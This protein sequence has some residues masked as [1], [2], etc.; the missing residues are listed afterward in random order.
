MTIGWCP[1]NLDQLRS[2]RT[3]AERGG[4]SRAAEALYL[5]QSTISMQIAAL[6]RELGVSLFD[7][8]GRRVTL[9]DAGQQLLRYAVSI[10][11]LAEE[12]RRAMEEI[13][14]IT[15][16]KLVIGA[17]RIIGTY[18]V[19]DLFGRFNADHPGVKLI[20][21]TDATARTAERVREGSLDVGLL[22]ARVSV[23]ELVIRPFR[24]D[25]LVLIVPP[26]H[27][28][29]ERGEIDA[30]ELVTERLITREP[31]EIIRQIVDR[32]LR[33]Q[34]IELKPTLELWAFEAIR[35]AVTA[36]LGVAIVPR[37]V[38]NL[39]LTAGV[40]AQVAVR[41]VRLQR[42]LYVALHRQKHIS[43]ALAAFLGLLGLNAGLVLGSAQ[44]GT[45][46]SL[47]AKRRR[48]RRPTNGSYQPTT[49]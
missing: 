5:A 9:T 37:V 39:A 28:W 17:G 7:R 30:R 46:A 33:D 35:Q 24:T 31:G 38:I 4:F 1:V 15:S 29:I 21:E 22:E 2:F 41:G 18:L 12:A 25:E 36:G 44:S 42:D 19:P 45:G 34:G 49:E 32:R 10:L 6:E 14:G 40:V 48:R 43:P 27:R 3:V 26:G 23:P 11:A 47:S 8:L 20:L 16:G 13:R